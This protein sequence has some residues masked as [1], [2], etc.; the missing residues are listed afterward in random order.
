MQMQDLKIFPE[1]GK[2]GIIGIISRYF[3]F[4]V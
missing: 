2:T 4:F 3:E 1:I